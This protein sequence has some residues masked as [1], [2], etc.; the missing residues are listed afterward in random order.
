VGGRGRG[1]GRGRGKARIECES[2]RPQARKSSN[3]LTQQIKVQVEGFGVYLALQFKDRTG[4][5]YLLCFIFYFFEI[6]ICSSSS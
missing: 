2:E 3:N 1:R 4:G 6:H 5:L